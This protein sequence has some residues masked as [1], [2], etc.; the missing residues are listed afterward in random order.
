M[1]LCRGKGQQGNSGL[2]SSNSV[3]LNVGKDGVMGARLIQLLP[4]L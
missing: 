3:M 4:Y 1:C 2:E